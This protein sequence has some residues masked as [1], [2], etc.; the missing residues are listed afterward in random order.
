[1]LLAWLQAEPL[2]HLCKDTHP[3]TRDEY[4]L[5]LPLGGTSKR[6]QE[7]ATGKL[8]VHVKVTLLRRM[9]KLALQ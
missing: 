9:H 6:R 5:A 7:G 2:A 8:R 4:R 3:A 1:L